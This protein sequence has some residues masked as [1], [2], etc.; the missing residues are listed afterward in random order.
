L[1]AG[2][3]GVSVRHDLAEAHVKVGEALFAAGARAEALAHYTSA[4]QTLEALSAAAPAH[5]GIRIM[6][7]ETCAKAGGLHVALA[8]A[9]TSAKAQ[10]R[11]H[12]RAALVWYRRSLE[13]WLD[14][15]ER[16]AEFRGRVGSPADPA[17][18]V[19]AALAECDAALTR[20]L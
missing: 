9:A 6:L 15:R 11:E 18:S 14:L 2:E 5:V 20:P 7:G 16:G 12:W 8:T 17:E 3:T 4:L 13:V 1:A 10:G 19:R